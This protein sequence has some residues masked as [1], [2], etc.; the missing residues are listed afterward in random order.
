MAGLSCGI[1]GPFQAIQNIKWVEAPVFL[2]CRAG[3]RG[4]QLEGGPFLCVGM[5]EIREEHA[6][7]FYCPSRANDLDGKKMHLRPH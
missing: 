4:N 3:M 1:C 2:C 6:K 5:Y 7:G